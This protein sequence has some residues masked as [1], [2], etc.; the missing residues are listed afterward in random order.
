M[1][2]SDRDKQWLRENPGFHIGSTYTICRDRN[3]DGPDKAARNE[4]DGHWYELYRLQ[5]GQKL[6]EAELMESLVEKS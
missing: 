5:Y 3:S 6:I 1:G 4:R 2:L